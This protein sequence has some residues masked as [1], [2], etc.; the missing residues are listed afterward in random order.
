MKVTANFF[1]YFLNGNENN[2]IDAL[3]WA[4]GYCFRMMKLSSK[5]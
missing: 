5:V 3:N 4:K 1:R 2:E